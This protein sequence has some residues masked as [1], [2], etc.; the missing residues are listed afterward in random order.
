MRG[1]SAVGAVPSFVARSSFSFPLEPGKEWTVSIDGVFPPQSR[2][3][4]RSHLVRDGSF[5]GLLERLGAVREAGAIPGI[6]HCPNEDLLWRLLVR[7]SPSFRGIASRQ[8]LQDLFRVQR[9]V[10]VTPK[11]LSPSSGEAVPVD[12][13][14]VAVRVVTEMVQLIQ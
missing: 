12:F 8:T 5:H 10:L 4:E 14:A 13:E 9:R 1:A 7:G 3:R 6:R 11:G 2:N